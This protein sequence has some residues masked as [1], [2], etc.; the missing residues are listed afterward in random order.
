MTYRFSAWASKRETDK[1]LL[2]DNRLSFASTNANMKLHYIGIIKNESKPAHE[3]VAEKDLSAYSR[4]TRNKY[5]ALFIYLVGQS[6][7]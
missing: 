5:A 6:R 1:R 7:Q 2:K 3:L 4:F